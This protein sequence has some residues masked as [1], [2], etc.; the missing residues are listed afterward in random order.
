MRNTKQKSILT[1]LI[2]PAKRKGW[3]TAV[4]FELGL[5]REGRDVLAL[6]QQITKLAIKYLESVIKNNLSEDLLNQSL[7]PRYQKILKDIKL[8]QK[9]QAIMNN[10]ISLWRFRT[11]K[12]RYVQEVSL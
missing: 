6:K 1:F 3:F 4:C 10:V 7:P 8:R 2:I 12:G 9:W 5:V 11:G